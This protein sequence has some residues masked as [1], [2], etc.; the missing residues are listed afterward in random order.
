[1]VASASLRQ[2]FPLFSFYLFYLFY[3][4]LFFKSSYVI[5][6]RDVVSSLFLFLYIYME[7]PSYN[8]LDIAIEKK[9]GCL[10]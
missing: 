9:K 4:I 10:L 1:M 3:F 8:N 2:S 6:I 7:K 5:D